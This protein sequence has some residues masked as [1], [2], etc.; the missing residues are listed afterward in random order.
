LPHGEDAG[1]VGLALGCEILVVKFCDFTPVAPGRFFA[2]LLFAGV[3]ED[4]LFG[5]ESFELAQVQALDPLV[6]AKR[7]T[8]DLWR[9]FVLFGFFVR[10]HRGVFFLH[11]IHRILLKE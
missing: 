3:V 4:Q 9:V 1:C 11:E 2:D 5:W 6:F 10:P 8:S 7:G